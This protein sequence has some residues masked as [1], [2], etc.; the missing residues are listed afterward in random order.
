M[1][2]AE[3]A[4]A[5]PVNPNLMSRAEWKRKRTELDSVAARTA[6][7]PRLFVLG[8]DEELGFSDCLVLESARKAGHIPLGTFD[9]QLAKL[10]GA[11][12]L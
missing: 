5:R 9:R 4:L 2:V 12:R 6:A 1:Q 7:Q 10:E 11:Q 8:S 3:T